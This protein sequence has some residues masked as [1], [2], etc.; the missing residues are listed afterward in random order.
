MIRAFNYGESSFDGSDDG[1]EE[2][3]DEEEDHNQD[4]F[5]KTDEHEVEEEE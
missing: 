3:E 1:D 2:I 5:P 4:L